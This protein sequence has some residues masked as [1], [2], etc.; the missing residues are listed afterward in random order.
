[1]TAGDIV[2]KMV[3]KGNNQSYILKPTEVGTVWLVRQIS[4]EG[5]WELYQTNGTQSIKI[6]EGS[7]NDFIGKLEIIVTFETWLEL[8]NVSGDE[9]D[10]G[11]GHV[12]MK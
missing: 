3:T 9:K 12:V 11:E 1:M 6:N 4:S 10:L 8:K 2:S 7:G 5:A